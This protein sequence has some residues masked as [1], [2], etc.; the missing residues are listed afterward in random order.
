[1][2]TNNNLNARIS[3]G[4]QEYPQ[5]NIFNYVTILKQNKAGI[6]IKSFFCK[7][8]VD[9][10]ETNAFKITLLSGGLL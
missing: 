8:V 4:K 7:T 6:S 2:F 3:R 1:M 5:A 9:T 10:Q